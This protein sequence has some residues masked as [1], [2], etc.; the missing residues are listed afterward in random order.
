MGH[1]MNLFCATSSFLHCN[2]ADVCK[3]QFLCKLALLHTPV[4][5]LLNMHFGNDRIIC[6]HFPTA[7]TP[8]SPDL[9]PC[10]FWLWGYLKDVVY[11]GPIANLDELK[12]RITQHIHNITTETLRSVVELAVLR[13][14]IIVENGI[15]HFLSKS[16]PN[17]F[18]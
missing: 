8:R 11:G 15:E 5:Q 9:N 3:A 10:D 4:K 2:S 7:W 17:Y 18:Y 13:F 16:K 12:N 14:Q 1:A 6:R